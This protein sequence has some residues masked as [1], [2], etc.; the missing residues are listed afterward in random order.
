MTTEDG[1]CWTAEHGLQPGLPSISAIS[2]PQSSAKKEGDIYDVI[3][4]GA[5]YTGLVATRD[6]AI[7]RKTI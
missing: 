2:P 3:V 7:Q 6:L 4:V 1:F 5:G